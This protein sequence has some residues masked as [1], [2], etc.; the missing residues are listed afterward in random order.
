MTLDGFSSLSRHCVRR[1]VKY[2]AATRLWNFLTV[3]AV[4]TRTAGVQQN[5]LRI[6]RHI[7]AGKPLDF[8]ST[9]TFKPRCRHS[10]KTELV[11]DCTKQCK[12]SELTCVKQLEQD[13]LSWIISRMTSFS[14]ATVSQR[15]NA[16]EVA[17]CQF[18]GML[19]TA[20]SMPA[21]PLEK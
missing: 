12:G 2:I 10:R 15:S 16:P 6:Q 7:G 17:F 14:L 3:T 8:A 9:G 18:S 21:Q 13:I 4:M 11:S 19:H 1:L 20:T 5:P